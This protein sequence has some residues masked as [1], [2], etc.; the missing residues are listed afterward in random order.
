MRIVVAMSG[1]VDSSVAAAL[2]VEQGHDVIGL[3]MQLYDQS[4]GER[5]FGSCCTLDDLHDARRVAR[6]L[7]IP[8]YI[9]NLERQFDEHVVSNFVRE[10]AAG[11]TPIPCARCNSDLKFSTLL[12][13]A[14]GFGA[15]VVATGH[16]AR[17]DRDPGTARHLL[18]RSLDPDKDQS[19]FLFSLSQD[20]LAHALFPVGDWSK[21]DVRE[22]ARRRG[23]LVADKPDSQEICFI[24]DHDYATFVATHS[25]EAAR[26]HGEI[27]D[28]AGRV[29]GRHDG[30]HRFTVGQRKG[31]G[32][33]RS[34]GGQPVYVLSLNPVEQQVIVGPKALLEKTTLTAS[35][36][37]WMIAEPSG[38]LEVTAQIRHRHRPA[39][40]T[41][42]ALGD[43]RAQLVFDAP[44]VAVT[45]GQAVVFY[46][47]DVV[48]GGGWID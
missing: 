8:H 4:D 30:I 19:Y 38:P 35:E 11:R 41:L 15:D 45:P 48:V 46:Q 17:L 31:L 20:Q 6:T 42:T 29:V 18:R 27:I 16:Y 10:Y 37:N 13:R 47:E 7:G 32:L 22:Y 21:D 5:T 14:R 2:V 9:V 36:V 40:A 12:T 24:P 28:T 25:P 34:P 26:A 43:R 1:G 33:S 44:Q 39:D 23:L 3:S